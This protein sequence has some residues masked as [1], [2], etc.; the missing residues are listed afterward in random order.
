MAEGLFLARAI[1]VHPGVGDGDLEALLQQ[2]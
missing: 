1:C 2:K